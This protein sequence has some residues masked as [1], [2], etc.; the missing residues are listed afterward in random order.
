MSETTPKC[1]SWRGHKFEARYSLETGAPAEPLTFEKIGVASI[2]EYTFSELFEINARQAETKTYERDICVRCG[3][4]I[5]RQ[6]I[7]ERAEVQA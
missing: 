1:S 2:T 3:H 4:V 5:E 7:N 6:I